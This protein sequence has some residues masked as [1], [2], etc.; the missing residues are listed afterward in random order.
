MARQP[1]W[2]V[3]VRRATEE[4]VSV[5]ADTALH[6]EEQAATFPNV[7]SVFGKSAIRGDKPVGTVYNPVGV[8]YDNGD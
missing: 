4:W 6:A 3:R 1:I 8:V 7:L 5:E 2:Q